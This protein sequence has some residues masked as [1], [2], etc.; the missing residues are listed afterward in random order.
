M[1]PLSEDISRIVVV[2][3]R[4]RGLRRVRE[5]ASCPGHRPEGLLN[6]LRGRAP[7]QPSRNRKCSVASVGAHDAQNSSAYLKQFYHMGSETL[8]I[9]YVFFIE[10]KF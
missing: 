1:M 3:Q 5:K 2:F 6:L 8:T 9:V 10:V 4:I 7:I